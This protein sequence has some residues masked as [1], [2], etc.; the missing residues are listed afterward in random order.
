M[1][2]HASLDTILVGATLK[3]ENENDDDDYKRNP[4]TLT[5]DTGN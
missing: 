5:T 4:L 3:I 2:P 1:P